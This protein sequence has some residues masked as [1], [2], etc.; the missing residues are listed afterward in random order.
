MAITNIIS[1][2]HCYIS[3]FVCLNYDI[4]NDDG[5][6]DRL[7]EVPYHGDFSHLKENHGPF[8]IKEWCKQN[9]E[10]LVYFNEL[11]YKLDFELEEDATA[12][13]LR[14]L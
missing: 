5:A 9:C 1:K 2:R 3:R 13:V 8:D 6:L 7:V 14:W 4:M 11:S 10:G 12:F